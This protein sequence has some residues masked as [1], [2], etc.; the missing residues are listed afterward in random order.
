MQ[1]G[2][3]RSTL[4]DALATLEAMWTGSSSMEA[5]GDDAWRRRAETLLVDLYECM[6]STSR[7]PVFLERDLE[8][9][10]DGIRW[11]GRA[12]RIET[13]A[14]GKLRVV[15]YKTSKT[16]P[17]A[18]EA[19]SR[20][21]WRS[22]WQPPKPTQR[23]P[24]RGSP[25]RRNTGTPWPSRKTKWIAFDPAHLDETLATMRDIASG[26]KNEDWTP[27]FGHHCRRCAVRL[28]CPLW[29]EGQE[30]YTR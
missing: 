23:S 21:S 22:T 3:D 26:I 4:E 16:P 28:V 14:E 19:A 2:R 9:E 29:P 1:E 11:R 6:D 7:T 25:P 5:L 13:Q 20:S 8:L 15:D 30:A 10:I 27:R 18:A 17:P 12:D 24:S